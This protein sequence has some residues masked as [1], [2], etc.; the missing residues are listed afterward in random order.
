MRGGLPCGAHIDQVAKEIVG[1][2]SG[3]IREHT[4]F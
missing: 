4:V 3:T 1:Q 2:L